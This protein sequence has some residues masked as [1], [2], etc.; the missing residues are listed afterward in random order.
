VNRR[1]PLKRSPK[2]KRR[3]GNVIK[4]CDLLFSRLIRSR[5]TCEVKPFWPHECK[6][7]SQT[8]HI[9][10][11]RYLGTRWSED[12]AINGCQAA[13]LF[14]TVRPLEWDQVIEEMFPGRL[15]DLKRRAL[16]VTKVDY[17]ATLERLRA[18]VEEATGQNPL[19]EAG[20]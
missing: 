1:L 13:H 4:D 12:N 7:N 19:F 18:A 20:A 10:S 9:V 2:K 3:K 17:P 14:Y 6:G 16:I 11:R 5:A 15:E 8:L